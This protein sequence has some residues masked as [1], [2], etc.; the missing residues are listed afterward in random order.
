M[1]IISFRHRGDLKKTERFLKKNYGVTFEQILESYGRAGVEALQRYTP[2]DSGITANS[3]NY[4]IE[5]DFMGYPKSI[6][7]TNSSINKGV[8]IALILQYGH[9]TGTGGY[10][11]GVDYINPALAP[12]FKKISESMWQEVINS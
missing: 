6:K 7:W 12:V 11:Q 3:W 2:K 8:N 4:V 1:S 5:R 9:G 10:V